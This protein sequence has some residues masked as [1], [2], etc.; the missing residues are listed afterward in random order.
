LADSD[1][2]NPIWRAALDSPCLKLVDLRHNFVS[3]GVFSA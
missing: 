3:L 2:T 1:E